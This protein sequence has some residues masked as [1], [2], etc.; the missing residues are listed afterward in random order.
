MSDVD[1]MLKQFLDEKKMISGSE[2]TFKTYSSTLKLFR[3]QLT[4]KGLDLFPLL[5]K[6]EQI[7]SYREKVIEEIEQY[8]HFQTPS[9][10]KLRKSVLS[11]FYR[12]LQTRVYF[13]NPVLQDMAIKKRRRNIRLVQKQLLSILGSIED[14]PVGKRDKAILCLLLELGI[15]N[16]VLYTIKANQFCYENSQFCFCLK[17]QTFPLCPYTSQVITDLGE[18]LYGQDWMNVN[19]PLFVSYSPSKRGKYEQ[20]TAQG[21]TGIIEKRTG[22]RTPYM[23]MSSFIKAVSHIGKK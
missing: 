4:S 18:S 21:I 23:E 6:E 13:P 10:A 16:W 17:E 1:L 12:F 14:T 20:V 5:D 3:D 22:E 7:E 8:L 15:P 11:S 19:L 2:R 9:T